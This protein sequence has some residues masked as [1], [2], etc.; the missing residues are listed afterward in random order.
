[1]SCYLSV[2]WMDTL[3]NVCILSLRFNYRM[4]ECDVQKLFIA[5]LN[6]NKGTDLL[7]QVERREKWSYSTFEIKSS[8]TFSSPRSLDPYGKARKGWN[9]MFNQRIQQQH[10]YFKHTGHFLSPH[11]NKIRGPNRTD[12][13][14]SISE[15]KARHW[16]WVES[17]ESKTIYN[18]QFLFHWFLTF[19]W[20]VT[21]SDQIL[22]Q[23]NSNTI[24]W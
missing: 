21:D 17:P 20:V 16:K 11:R 5:F 6:K 4:T 10:A 7:C 2:K 13:K 3:R 1:M 22:Y 23:D 12:R 15:E 24:C 18:L 8:V 14:G 9:K 19:F